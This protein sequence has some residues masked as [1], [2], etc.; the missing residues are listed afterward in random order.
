MG[1]PL[2]HPGVRRDNQNLHV[3]SIE[4]S[5]L[6]AQLREICVS[7]GS[8]VLKNKRQ[9]NG[10]LAAELTEAVGLA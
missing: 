8:Y 2:F 4:L 3:S 9:N 5:G 7:P 10:F 6:F 1:T